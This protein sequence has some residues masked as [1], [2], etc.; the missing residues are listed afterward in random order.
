M[1]ANE[2][3]C[4]NFFTYLFLIETNY[5]WLLLNY[6]FYNNEYYKAGGETKET[7]KYTEKATERV[8][9]NGVT[10]IEYEENTVDVDEDAEVN[11]LISIEFLLV[12]NYNY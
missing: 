11:I 8:D 9:E 5:V 12:I 4:K 1:E 3:S 6:L 7:A 2:S 10:F